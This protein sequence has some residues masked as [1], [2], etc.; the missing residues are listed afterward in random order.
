MLADLKKSCP[1]CGCTS[2]SSNLQISPQ[3]THLRRLRGVLYSLKRKDDEYPLF[4]V[5]KEDKYLVSNNEENPAY[6]R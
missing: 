1:D 6:K 2:L 3:R 5:G 4:I